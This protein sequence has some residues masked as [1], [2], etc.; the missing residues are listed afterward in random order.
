V[1]R[2]SRANCLAAP[3]RLPLPAATTIA[4]VDT[5]AT[6]RDPVVITGDAARLAG[7]GSSAANTKRPALVG[8]ID[9]TCNCTSGPPT[10]PEPPFTTTIEPS[11][12]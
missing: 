1:N 8:T 4:H 2:P 6:Y 3:K 12:R 5:L 11:S 7:Y 10:R 9:V